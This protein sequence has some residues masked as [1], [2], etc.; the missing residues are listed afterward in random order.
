MASLDALLA[1]IIPAR[2]AASLTRRLLRAQGIGAGTR[3]GESGERRALAR[4]LNGKHNPIVFD[5][6]ANVGAWTLGAKA[7]CPG[8]Q[9]HAFEP[10][11]SHRTQFDASTRALSDVT[12]VPTALSAETGTATLYKDQDIT[13]L[14]SLTQRE[15]SHKGV[16]MDQ[17]E[18]IET[19]TLD[20][21]V[22]AA[23]V[24]H[25]DYLKIDVEGHELDVLR[26]AQATLAANKIGAVQFEF[27]G[28]N[29]DTRT[30]L[31]DFYALFDGLG[32]TLHIIRPNG[33]LA[34]M[35]GY[36]EYYEQF[37]TTNY[38]ALPKAAA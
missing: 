7:V 38:L 31:R 11:Q 20:G 2:L 28:C 24:S 23:G 29:V 18:T 25:I 1:Q 35:K 30:F 6:G 3:A 10:S 4:T 36:R 37:A 32:Y 34:P 21:Y 16:T 9:I 5:V 22:A 17:T 8:A 12:L 15:L 27:G 19:Q 14:A 13:G 26:G 33:A